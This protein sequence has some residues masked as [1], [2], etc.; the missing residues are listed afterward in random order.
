[1]PSRWEDFHDP[2][3]SPCQEHVPGPAGLLIGGHAQYVG[4]AGPRPSASPRGT[5]K[6]PVY[7]KFPQN[8]DQMTEEEQQAFAEQVA[9]EVM[10]AAEAEPAPED[11]P[12]RPS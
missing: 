9:A 8:W 3:S 2:A 1:M 4:R 6:R 10:A 12:T 5:M 11:D 7:F